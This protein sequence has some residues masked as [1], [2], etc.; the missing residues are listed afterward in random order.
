MLSAIMTKLGRLR[1][2][3]RRVIVTVTR[4]A[5]LVAALVAALLFVA[6]RTGLIERYFIYFPRE[7]LEADP[8][9]FGL[10]F[11]D[12]FFSA[13]DG[14]ELHGWFV[15]GRNEVTW[16][17][18]HGNAGNISDRLE[19]L[20]LLHDEL[21]V[22]VF[23]FDYRGYGR[24]KGRPTEK[25]TY[26]DADAALG[27]LRSRSDV[28]SG[29]IIYFGRSLGAAVAVELA[30]RQQPYGLILESP[31]LSVRHMARLAYRFLPIWAVVIDRYDSLAKIAKVE[32]PVL[33]L[34]G[35]EDDTVPIKA[36]KKLF[37]A[38]SAPKEFFTVQGAG[39]NDVYI[40]GGRSYVTALQAFVERLA[41]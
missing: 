18:F 39:H 33:V 35:D 6:D 23:L 41:Q 38:V 40:V 28:S 16:L 29:R 26:L 36:G 7:K 4:G 14:T 27:Y 5:V 19:N 13:A 12:I 3:L 24:S 20:K 17:W 32:A 8:S 15:P 34:H 31:F 37:D 25:G 2:P 21:G 10:A 9:L 22:N 1:I 30:T 11:E